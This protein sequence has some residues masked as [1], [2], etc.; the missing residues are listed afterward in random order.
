MV[1]I[2]IDSN[3]MEIVVYRWNAWEWMQRRSGMKTGVAR[4]LNL[5]RYYQ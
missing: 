1:H 3:G 4:I 2:V 5:F